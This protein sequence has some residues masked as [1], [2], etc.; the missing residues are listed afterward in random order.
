MKSDLDEKDVETQ[1]EEQEKKVEELEN[2]EGD[3]PA[4]ESDLGQLNIYKGSM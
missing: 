2:D 1:I 3:A 4:D